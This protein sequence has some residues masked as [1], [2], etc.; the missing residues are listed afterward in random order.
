MAVI[1]PIIVVPGITA[2][3][4][5]DEYPL[6]PEAVWKVLEKEYDR[7]VLHP[8]DLRF[9]AREPARLMPG[10]IFEVAYKELIEELRYNLR[11]K[12]DEPVPVYP[13]SYDWRMP[14]D[15]IETRLDQFVDE[16]IQRTMLLRH[17]HKAGFGE[18]PKVNLVGHSMGGLVITGYLERRGAEAPV[19]KVATFAT[20]YQGSFEAVIQVATGTAMLGTSSPSSRQREAARM[21]PALYHLLPGFKK[22]IEADPGIPDSLF[23]PEAW[24]PSVVD[25]IAEF[26]RLKGLPTKQ[27]REDAKAVFSRLL[28][29]AKK[30]RERINGFTLAKAG[31]KPE[32]WLAVVGV[33]AETRV[34][35]KIVKRGGAPE[36]ALFSSDR[37][38]RWIKEKD[39]LLRRVT[40]DGTVPFEGAVPMFL[41][42]ENLVCVTPDDYGYWEVQ[43]KAFSKL[44]GFHGI[45]PNMDMLH[46]LLVR[47]FTGRPDVHGNTWGRRVPG[48]QTWK[49]PIKLR[50]RES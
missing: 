33:D 39:P 45:L 17:Y 12:E 4:L 15:S 5:N 40:G 11:A 34:R 18:T 29:Q 16:V 48:V 38:N 44:A 26:I 27:R 21:T 8:N 9:E 22:G 47:F 25:S 32:D 20:P 10:Q 42:E 46:R 6:P 2:T 49:P 50:E 30:H 28:T 41:K 23:N 37:D 14:L 24:Q 3:C 1:Y 19:H 36:F 7:I 35:L 43:D 13:F 31:L